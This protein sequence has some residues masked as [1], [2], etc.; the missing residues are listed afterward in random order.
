MHD[1][2]F[3]YMGLITESFCPTTDTSL[4]HILCASSTCIIGARVVMGQLLL[5]GWFCLYYW[6]EGG[7][8][9]TVVGGLVLPVL[10]VRGWWWVNCCWRAGSACII[11]AR[12]VMGQLLLEGWFCLYYWCEG[13]STVVSGLV[14]PVLLVRGRWWV[15]CCWW[16]GSA[17]AQQT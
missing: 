11:G 9:S 17:H 14:L 15:N 10:L 2:P 3:S 12:V 1:G 8:G 6:C 7:D 16:A 4:V 13:G 5:A